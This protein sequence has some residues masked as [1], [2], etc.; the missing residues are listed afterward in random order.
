MF[1]TAINSRKQG[2]IGLG[3]AIAW[4]ASIGQTVSIPLT[5]NQH[6]DLVVD[7]GSKLNKV[8]V[9]TSGC[10]KNNGVYDVWLRTCGGNRSSKGYVRPFNRAEVDYVFVLLS[11]GRRYV[12][13]S[14]KI[15]GVHHICIGNKYVKYM[16]T[17]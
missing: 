14:S 4:Y 7:D 8:Q 12:I 1:K 13:P 15:G 16:I 10:K 17:G 9:K 2:D 5:D 3:S 6:Y 11:D